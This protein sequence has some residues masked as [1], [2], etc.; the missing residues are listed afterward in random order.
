MNTLLSIISSIIAILAV[1]AIYELI[2]MI[3][4]RRFQRKMKVTDKCLFR[5]GNCWE[6]GRIT[7]IFNNTVIIEDE[8]GDAHG[9]NKTDVRPLSIFG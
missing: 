4:I 8:D 1:S 3:I 2:G 5:T 6:P 7:A 9:L